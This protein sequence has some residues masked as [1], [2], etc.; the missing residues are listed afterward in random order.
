MVVQ[1]LRFGDANGE[2]PVNLA[3]LAHLVG[4]FAAMY[5]SF[6]GVESIG[7]LQVAEGYIG[8]FLVDSD[9]V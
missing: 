3:V 6:R 7:F 1:S 5:M 4:R 2:V 9:I 8:H